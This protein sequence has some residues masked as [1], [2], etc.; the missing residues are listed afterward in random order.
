MILTIDAGNTNSVFALF[1]QQKLV[2]TW[3]FASNPKRT[4]D[5]YAILL[6]GALQ[7]EGW[8][9]KDIIGIIIANVVPA[10]DYPL[11]KLCEQY[12]NQDPVVV[13]VDLLQ[14]LLA[15]D[16][17]H[18]REVGADRLVNAIAAKVFYQLPALI[19][20][21]GTA[22]TIDVIDQAGVYKGGII[23]PGVHL[24]VQALQQAAAKLPTI[25]LQRPD[26]VIGRNTVTAMQSGIYWGYVGLI[27][28]L[29]Y[30]IVESEGWNQD[31]I[32]YIAT[33]G[34]AGFFYQDI[35][36]KI[37]LDPDLTLKGLSYIYSHLKNS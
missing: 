7:L 4:A 13:K 3:R 24:S 20:D 26:H 19:V 6:L 14:S 15:V 35:R 34:L 1:D 33:G 37:I 11:R 29:L 22:T 2:K 27:K 16:V 30:R 25:A 23:A 21:L 32:C 5:D 18:P 10:L 9:P 28:E 8:G 17:D 31:E 36:A 12:F